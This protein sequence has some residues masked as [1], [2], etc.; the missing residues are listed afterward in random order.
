MI[1]IGIVYNRFEKVEIQRIDRYKNL[2]VEERYGM[3]PQGLIVYLIDNSTAPH[4]GF[5]SNMLWNQNPLLKRE[6]CT[7]LDVQMMGKL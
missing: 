3:I 1:M 5:S 7:A 6:D 2:I 4:K